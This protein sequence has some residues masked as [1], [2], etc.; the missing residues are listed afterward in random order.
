MV[1][2]VHAVSVSGDRVGD[3]RER[4]ERA[5]EA[6]IE[7][8]TR[9]RDRHV[10]EDRDDQELRRDEIEHPRERERGKTER[11]NPTLGHVA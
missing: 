9:E 1:S 7:R 6:R 5:C 3:E 4:D 2:V 8:Q 10:E 11:S